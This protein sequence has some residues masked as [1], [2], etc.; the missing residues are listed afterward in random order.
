MLA[1]ALGATDA[2][3]INAALIG[4]YRLLLRDDL[5][6]QTA[7]AAV[8]RTVV[9]FGLVLVNLTV[10]LAYAGSGLYRV[11]RGVSRIDESFKVL[12]AVSLGIFGFLISNALQPQIGRDPLP[13]GETMFIP[14]WLA[15]VA[16]GV[17]AR[18]LYRSIVS[19]LRMRGIDNRNLLIIGAREAGRAVLASIRRSPD[20]GYRVQGFLSDSIP[21]GTMIDGLAVL[22]RT[23]MLGR[24]IR[25][26]RA[27]EIV[28]ALSGRTSAE[29]FDIVALAEDEAVEIRLYPDA[30]QLITNNEISVGDISGLPLISLRNVALDSPINQVLK[31]LLDLT[32]SFLVLTFL[33]PVML[34]IAALIRLESRGP[35]FFVQQRVG[36][37]N[38]P[39]P[40][41]KF[42]TMRA[43][44]P[45][46]GSWTTRDDPRVTPLGAFLRRYS[47]DEL[48]QFVNVIRGE[49]S[50]VGP[51]PEQLQW[52]ERFSR[53][54]P[55]Y[56]SR[57]R[58]KAGITGWAQ[59]N[60]LRGDTS[61][62][63]RTRYDL[64]Y[65][66]NWSLLFD[67]KIIIKTI[68]DVLIGANRGY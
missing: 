65:T 57:H 44:A 46:L 60:G 16:S 48:P 39:F 59:V 23:E 19:A 18:I 15:A 14:V 3:V 42:R 5:A 52:V 11:R 31:R 13:I 22:G 33:A 8:D 32:V 17:L 25:A 12:V 24:V 61:I 9:V 7:L 29:V 51:R 36:M 55:R 63:E 43:D 47:L 1:L 62:E 58:H 6:L 66:E 35:V 68:V 45:D 10:L 56:M 37:D 30:F 38:N 4:A 41:L 34:L 20:L 67:L 40:T 28:I 27:D 49:M 54:I 26:T 2:L 53:S 64:Y 50:V 21:V